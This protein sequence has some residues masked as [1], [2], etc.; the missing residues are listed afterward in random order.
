MV[1]F[2]TLAFLPTVFL[3]RSPTS[4]KLRLH[5]SSLLAS[6]LA[7]ASSTIGQAQRFGSCSTTQLDGS[8][9]NNNNNPTMTTTT[10]NDHTGY[11]DA[12]SA[13]ALDEELMSTPGFTLEQLMELAGLA[14]AQAAYQV[15]QEQQTQTSKQSSKQSSK[16]KI[17]IICGPGNNGGDGLVAARHLTLFGYDCTIVYP[18]DTTDK[19]PHYANL[20]Q[21]CRDMQIP[22]LTDVPEDTTHY[23]MWMDAIFGF[24]F[25]GGAPRPP[26]DTILAQLRAAQEEEHDATILLAVDVPS[27]W[28]VDEGDIHETG[29]LPDVLVS[30]TAPKLCAQNYPRRHFVGGRFL[31]PAVADKYRIRMPAYPGTDQ[32]MEI[33]RGGGAVNYKE[34]EEFT[35][36]STQQAR[37]PTKA[38]AH[39][40]SSSWEDDYAA[41]MAEKEAPEFAAYARGGEEN[42]Q[43]QSAVKPAT[44]SSDPNEGW[45]EDYAAYL[46]AKEQQSATAD[47]APATEKQQGL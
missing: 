2:R 15:L 32:V 17:L 16:P 33:S 10:M 11:L 34:K 38:P 21:Q 47:K 44:S 43:A 25:Q 22:I 41:Y 24:S 8:S 5:S 13:A 7:L 12:A 26:F 27:G 45:E 1:S 4:T 28:H 29:Y 9:D 37:T 30:L 18:K 36:S 23:D 46:A 42:K 14:V 35:S 6:G 20:L 31:P 40:S 19:Q 39:S 3:Q